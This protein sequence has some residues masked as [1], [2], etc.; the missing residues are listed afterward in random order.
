MSK[1]TVKFGYNNDLEHDSYAAWENMGTK[2]NFNIDGNVLGVFSNNDHQ[3]LISQVTNSYGDNC[4][5]GTIDA[6]EV[7]INGYID[8]YTI[9]SNNLP[10]EVCMNIARLLSQKEVKEQLSE[11]KNIEQTS[12]FDKLARLGIN[13]QRQDIQLGETVTVCGVEPEKFE[14]F[15][16]M[17]KG[18]TR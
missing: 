8:S 5:V 3:I 14:Q 16:I 7:V 17:E 12:G 6:R 2:Y 4:M 10:S 18:K 1:T 15:K 9:I 13:L 11:G